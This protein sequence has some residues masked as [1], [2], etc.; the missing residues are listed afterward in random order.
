M[1]IYR[2]LSRQLLAATLAVT[3][4]LVFILV[5]GRFIKY[6]SEVASGQLAKEVLLAIMM[7][8]V[9]GFLEMILPLGLFLAILMAYGRLYLENEMTVLL[10]C[11]F[12]PR[13]L[14]IHTLVPMLSMTAVVGLLSLWLS[15]WGAQHAKQLIV[16]Q[17]ARSS[18]ETLT[19]GRFHTTR[20]RSQV[21]YAERLSQDGLRM[22]HIITIQEG[23]AGFTVVTAKQGWRRIDP[24]TGVQYLMLEDGYQYRGQP[25]RAD[26]KVVAFEG[27]ELKISGPDE[28]RAILDIRV[29]STNAL[30]QIDSRSAWAELQWRWS[31]PLLV[32]IVVAIAIPLS[33][34]N[35]R[36]GRF[37]KMLPAI[38]LY[39]LYLTL[40]TSGRSA[41]E[42]GR[43]P[44]WLGLWWVHAAFIGVAVSLN[45]WPMWQRN[46]RHKRMV[47]RTVCA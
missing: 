42:E 26:L 14:F 24:N 33:R 22:E 1:I 12:G 9:P 15:P 41:I 6:L 30:F 44:M 31:L 18:F 40:L 8:R 43:W 4:V 10:A 29:R 16:D 5:S 3:T 36:Q 35:P 39:L 2:Y 25:G 45:A 13:Q 19:P 7:Y 23:A 21:T 32:P 38:L 37:M 17:R 11:G 20:D 28:A 34:V 27:Y 46:W 47:R